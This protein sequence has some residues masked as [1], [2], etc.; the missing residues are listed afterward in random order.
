MNKL[1][2]RKMDEDDIP[3]ILGI[4]RISFGSPC[5]EQFFLYAIYKKN[6]FS[7]VAVFEKSIIGYICVDHLLHESHVLDLAVHPDFRRLGVASLLINDAIRELK[8]RG[9]VFM[10]LEVRASN[11]GA[12]RFY[13]LFGFKVVSI[14]KKYYG[15][16]DED[17][18]LMEARL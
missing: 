14:R 18:L 7:Q 1:I 11:S 17:A 10:Y 4:E 15:K 13:E 2:I 6:A 12:Q 9:C 3:A 5:A 16:P 8:K